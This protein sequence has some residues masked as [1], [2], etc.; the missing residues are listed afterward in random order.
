MCAL[1]FTMYLKKRNNYTVVFRVIVEVIFISEVD[2][3]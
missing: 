1:N 2:L 3:E